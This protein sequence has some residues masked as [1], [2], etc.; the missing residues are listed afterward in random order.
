MSNTDTLPA[1]FSTTVERCSSC[2]GR[3]AGL[4]FDV[5]PAPA[6]LFDD[7]DT[8]KPQRDKG[9]THLSHCPTT[10]ARL[11]LRRKPGA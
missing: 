4:R 9:Y 2:A 1:A 8:Y 11:V 10:G 5:L 6:T 3:H 7:L